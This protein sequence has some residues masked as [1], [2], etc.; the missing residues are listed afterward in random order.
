[1]PRPE[2]STPASQDTGDET[3]SWDLIAQYL[4]ALRVRIRLLIVLTILIVLLVL[5]AYTFMSP[6]YAAEAVIGPPSPSPTS[7]FMTGSGSSTNAAGSL[8]RRV[9]GGASQSGNDPFEEYVQL[10]RS[11]RVANLLIEKHHILQIVFAKRWD[12]ANNRWLPPGKVS[13]ALSAL[14]AGLNRPVSGDPDIE[15]L[16]AFLDKNFGISAVSG[17]S[18]ATPSPL[19]ATA[20]LR[21]SLSFDDPKNAEDILSLILTEADN[22]I[23]EDLRR[24]VAARLA[25]LQSETGKVMPSDQRDALISVLSQQKQLQMMIAADQR[26]ASTLVDPPH[27]SKFPVSPAGPLTIIMSAI[28]LSFAAWIV[29]IYLGL[30]FSP[31]GR[32]VARTDRLLGIKTPQT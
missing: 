22:L 27:A 17:S 5:G 4:H 20:Y 29:L 13:R 14:N 7:T 6:R 32:F 12:A 3:F 28:L 11:V 18:G 8:A 24:D 9:L 16:N 21:V 1:M 26:Y 23:R 15:S 10:L 2:D 30:K 19:S 25:F 31:F